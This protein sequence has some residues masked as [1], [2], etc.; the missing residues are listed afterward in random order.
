MSAV[1][2]SKNTKLCKFSIHIPSYSLVEIY[3]EIIMIL[4]DV[5]AGFDV[6]SPT[7]LCIGYR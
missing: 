1:S 5:R 3:S 4:T 6:R 7:Q 2:N